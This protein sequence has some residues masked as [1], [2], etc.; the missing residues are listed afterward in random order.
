MDAQSSIRIIGGKWR[1]R[2]VSF[3][4]KEDLRPTPDRVR[5]TLFNWLAPYIVGTKCLDLYAGS[6]VLGF[7]ALSRGAESVMSIEAD[8]DC[9]QQILHNKEVLHADAMTVHNHNALDWLHTPR[10]A[11]DIVF[12]DPPYKQQILFKTLQLLDQN[13]WVAPQGLVYFELDK[14]IDSAQLPA[15]WTIWRSSK[16]GKV[17]YFLALNGEA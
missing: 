10:F 14:P 15:R 17:Y 6:G 3:M 11:A 16:A 13:N 2:K 5:E 8:R 12:A 1:S 7:E 4:T 9:C